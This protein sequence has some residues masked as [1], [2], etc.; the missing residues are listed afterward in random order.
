M[1]QH[2]RGRATPLPAGRVAA[3]PIRATLRVARSEPTARRGASSHVA[4]LE[5]SQAMPFAPL[6]QPVPL[7]AVGSLHAITDVA[8]VHNSL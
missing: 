7:L 5:R 3:D 2:R 4:M 6:A 1:P 8:K